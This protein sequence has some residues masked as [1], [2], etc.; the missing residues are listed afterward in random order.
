MNKKNKDMLKL[1]KLFKN[2]SAAVFYMG[3]KYLNKPAGKVFLRNVYK[4]EPSLYL[5][6]FKMNSNILIGFRTFYCGVDTYIPPEL[7]CCWISDH[8]F[9][10]VFIRTGVNSFNIIP[11]NNELYSVRF[12]RL[13]FP[14]YV[15]PRSLFDGF[16][17]IGGIK[18][19][20]DL[21][22]YNND[23]AVLHSQ[24][25]SFPEFEHFNRDKISDAVRMYQFSNGIKKVNEARK[26]LASDLERT[27]SSFL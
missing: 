21:F 5:F 25:I 20:I 27:I 14:P 6:R 23:E 9:L 4:V 1:N 3:I 10:S 18:S 19:W 26:K 11:Y 22:Y 17:L 16:P 13:S 7:K 24:G 12:R 8:H 15:D 2:L